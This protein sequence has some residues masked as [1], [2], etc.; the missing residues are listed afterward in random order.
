MTA[1]GLFQR[2]SARLVRNLGFR[3]WAD[4]SLL[5]YRVSKVR[6]FIR[7]PHPLAELRVLHISDLHIEGISDYCERLRRCLTALEADLCVISGDF[8]DPTVNDLSEVERRLAAVVCSIRTRHG[9]FAVLGDHDPPLLGPLLERIGIQLVAGRTARVDHGGTTLWVA[10]VEA[11]SVDCI[12]PSLKP[13]NEPLLFIG[14][15]PD[16]VVQAAAKGAAYFFC[17]HTHGGQVCLP[18]GVPLVSRCKIGRR[19]A[20]GA[21]VYRGTPGYTTRGIGICGEGFREDVKNLV[22]TSMSDSWVHC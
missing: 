10:G 9:I 7:L 20:S 1:I 13:P 21:W 5:D 11:E 18:G 3:S 8:V 14:H 22:E 17:G 19:F 4:A 15:S 2:A 6:A 12:A 16:Q